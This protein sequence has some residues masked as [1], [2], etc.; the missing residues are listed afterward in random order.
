MND[1]DPEQY[2]RV[3]DSLE[4]NP[5]A[6]NSWLWPPPSQQ[7]YCLDHFLMECEIY[8]EQEND[9][10]NKLAAHSRHLFLERQNRKKPPKISNP[11]PTPTRRQPTRRAKENHS[12]LDMTPPLAPSEPQQPPSTKRPSSASFK[13][14]RLER[15][16]AKSQ[17][18]AMFRVLTERHEEL[19]LGTSWEDYRSSLERK[20]QETADRLRAEIENAKDARTNCLFG[21][22]LGIK[23]RYCGFVDTVPD[24]DA[25]TR[26]KLA[27]PAAMHTVYPLAR[28]CDAKNPELTFRGVGFIVDVCGE[29]TMIVLVNFKGVLDLCAELFEKEDAIPSSPAGLSAYLS[30]SKPELGFFH[31]GGA[32][33]RIESLGSGRGPKRWKT[34]IGSAV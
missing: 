1:S 33:R 26:R 30:N 3:E 24:G 31:V 27:A 4:S 21:G 23:C 32:K 12:V 8:H 19:K 6:H 7:A 11:V 25:G 13:P 5:R 28:N 10:Y 18:G 16:F 20:I 2:D 22:P 34:S 17:E 15:A 9:R 14:Q 29:E